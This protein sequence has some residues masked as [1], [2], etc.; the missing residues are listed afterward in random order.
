MLGLLEKFRPKFV[1]RY[2]ELGE[3]IRA[4]ASNY[5]SD[6]TDG[7]FPGEVESFK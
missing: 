1:R 5:V 4:A 3:L 6:V 7:R 2:A